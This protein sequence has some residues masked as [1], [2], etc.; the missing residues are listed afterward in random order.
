MSVSGSQARLN[1]SSGMAPVKAVLGAKT[2]GDSEA[3]ARYTSQDYGNDTGHLMLRFSGPSSY[4][5]AGLDA[6][7][8]SSVLDI[9][10]DSGQGDVK[11]ASVP[12]AAVDGTS[13]WERVRVEGA[14]SSAKISVRAWPDGTPEPSTW[15]LTYSDASPLPAGR[16]GIQAWDGGSGWTLDSFS[17][18]N[19][20]SGS[21]ASFL[22]RVP[23][24]DLALMI[25]GWL[26]AMAY[27]L[28]PKA[29]LRREEVDRAHTL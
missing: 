6:P 7:N 29:G 22:G 15:N 25:L 13:Y 17:A 11:V 8:G 23:G 9:M 21:Q 27:V 1:G 12:F 28:L 4:Y 16:V 5:V 10:R 18:G 3:V 26:V 24:L 19:L 2:A 14:G 20:G